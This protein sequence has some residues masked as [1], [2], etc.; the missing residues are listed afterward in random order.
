MLVLV[1][2][3]EVCI[4]EPTEYNDKQL[5]LLTRCRTTQPRNKK[6][7]VCLQTTRLC[8]VVVTYY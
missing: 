5:V 8:S 2:K 1:S 7:C 3:T 6:Y 4:V